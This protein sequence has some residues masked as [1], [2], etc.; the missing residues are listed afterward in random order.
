MVAEQRCGRTWQIGGCAAEQKTFVDEGVPNSADA[1]GGDA[2]DSVRA[3]QSV[4]QNEQDDLQ[5]DSSMQ[6]DGGSQDSQSIST[7][8]TTQ[9]TELDLASKLE[10]QRLQVELQELQGAVH[11]FETEIKWIAEGGDTK[12]QQFQA[13]ME[14]VW[15]ELRLHS[16]M[17]SSLQQL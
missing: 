15:E 14:N 1:T 12:A 13:E 17:Q 10:V 8:D 2:E 4:E 6:D 11:N 9:G 5:G 3:K 16:E 7:S